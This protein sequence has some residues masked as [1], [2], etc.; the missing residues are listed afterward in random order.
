[1]RSL[2]GEIINGSRKRT[3]RR[4]RLGPEFG[5]M[6]TAGVMA[7]MLAGMIWYSSGFLFGNNFHEEV[8]G[9]F[10][11]S[12]RLSSDDLE[13][14]IRDK[15]LRTV[16]TFTAGSDRHSWYVDQK[17]ICQAHRVELYPVNLNAERLP[18]RETLEQLIEILQRSPHR[19]SS[20]GT[21]GWTRAGSPRR[22]PSSSTGRRRTWRCGNSA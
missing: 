20:R 10:F 21:G 14:M 19:S 11:R 6:A 13:A 12:A 4:G 1:M 3:T 7:M 18:P 16:V 2:V 15:G 17:R 8:P 5:W 22:S 9:E